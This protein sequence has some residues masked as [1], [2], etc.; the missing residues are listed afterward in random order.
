[1]TTTVFE[2]V[3]HGSDRY[4]SKFLNAGKFDSAGRTGMIVVPVF[5]QGGKVSRTTFLVRVFD[6]IS[7]D[8]DRLNA[9]GEHGRSVRYKEMITKLKDPRNATCA[10]H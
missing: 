10:M 8:E 1:M 5:H 4:W 9:R 3:L 6:T 2:T 7:N